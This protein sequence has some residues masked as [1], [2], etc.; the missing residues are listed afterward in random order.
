M[1]VG[2]K[3]ADVARCTAVIAARLVCGQHDKLTV[4]GVQ[5]V[6]EGGQ[7]SRTVQSETRLAV[8]CQRVLRRRWPDWYT[9]CNLARDAYW[10]TAQKDGLAQCIAMLLNVMAVDAGHHHRNDKYVPIERVVRGL[11][12]VDRQSE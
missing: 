10:A 11:T 5:T 4:C 3:D 2:A 12:G 6:V 1:L 8:T 9:V 7:D